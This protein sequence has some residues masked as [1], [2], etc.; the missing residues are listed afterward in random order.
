MRNAETDET[1]R[2][3]D[4]LDLEAPPR[5]C[6]KEP[7]ACCRTVGGDGKPYA[8]PLVISSATAR[9]CSLCD[10]RPEARQPRGEFR[11]VVLRDR[12]NEDIAARVCNRGC[13]SAIA[14]GNASPVL[15][16]RRLLVGILE[17][18]SA[19]FMESGLKYLAGQLERVSVIRIDVDSVSGEARRS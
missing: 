3:G 10:R 15:A 8:V 11:R 4:Q 18:Y 17:K 7:T 6:R 14:S 12:S 13:E 9:S 1:G 5:C 2:Q 16:K 19:D